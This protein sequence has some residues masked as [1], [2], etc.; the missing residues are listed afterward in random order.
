ME[1]LNLNS[2]LNALNSYWG[3]GEF[4]NFECFPSTTIKYRDSINYQSIVQQLE[5]ESLIERKGGQM[6]GRRFTSIG[7]GQTKKFD[8]RRYIELH[9]RITLKGHKY[10]NDDVKTQT[11]NLKEIIAKISTSIQEKN[12][13]FLLQFKNKKTTQLD[14]D[15]FRSEFYR[16]ISLNFNVTSEEESRIGRTDLVVYFGKSNR[17]ILE[18]KVWGRN[19][20]KDTVKQIYGYLT[21][22]DKEGYILMVNPNRTE[23]IDKYIEMI[24]NEKMGF[25]SNSFEELEVNGFKYYKSEHKINVLKKT[26]YHFILNVF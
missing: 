11:I 16:I 25:I 14:E 15:D 6:V 7:N 13:K 12:P 17:S 20:Y 19:D 22:S 9:L 18:F 24:K 23:I 4:Y 1:K 8:N 2:V 3:N 21:D 10:L 5:N 26:I